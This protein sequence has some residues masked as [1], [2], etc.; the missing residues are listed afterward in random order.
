MLSFNERGYNSNFKKLMQ[1]SKKYS[2]DFEFKNCLVLVHPYYAKLKKEEDLSRKEFKTYY[3]NLKKI[4][5]PK[6][7]LSLVLYEDPESYAK[8]TSELVKEGIFD[9]VIFSEDSS[10]RPHSIWDLSY[11]N[12]KNVFIGGLY[13][14]QCLYEAIRE[15]FEN[16]TVKK[17]TPIK[18]LVMDS[19][20]FVGEHDSLFPSEVFYK[21]SYNSPLDS[22]KPRSFG[23]FYQQF[24]N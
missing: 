1:H 16:S 24:F 18:E 19:C 23:E 17:I 11:F 8:K 4:W 14:G 2:K 13:N 21:K 10:G 22:M 5:K 20:A 7:D 6:K 3:S 15:I 12:N 9:K